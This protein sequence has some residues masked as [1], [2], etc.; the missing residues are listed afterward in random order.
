MCKARSHQIRV[1]CC[2]ANT[3]L[4]QDLTHINRP[5]NKVIIIDTDPKAVETHLDN[6]IVL[7]KWTG[8][9]HDKTLFDLIPLLQGTVMASSSSIIDLCPCVVLLLC[10]A[11]ALNEVDDIRPVL[12]HY[13]SEG[14][15][16][17]EVFKAHQAKLLEEEMRRR[18]EQKRL[19]ESQHKIGSTIVPFSLGSF[20]HRKHTP[21]TPQVRNY[22]QVC[23]SDGSSI[24]RIKLPQ[25]ADK[26][27]ESRRAKRHQDGHWDS[28]LV[29][30]N[31][32]QKCL[33][34]QFPFRAFVMLIQWQPAIVH[35]LSTHVQYTKQ[36]KG[37]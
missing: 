32:L 8:D 1:F 37:I 31:G 12:N 17:V 21:S 35:I 10:V 7:P 24:A 14:G 22:L 18:E 9:I 19:L 25:T 2:A 34:P 16:V 29:G 30:N 33:V 13:K 27:Q 23:R 5:L 3:V 11:I 4:L 36:V 26:A 20:I 28:G 15:N 6:S